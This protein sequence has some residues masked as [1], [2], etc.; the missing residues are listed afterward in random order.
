MEKMSSRE[1]V[2]TTIRHEEPDRVP[3]FAFSVDPKFIKAWG[4]GNPLRAFD[5][6]GL[7][8]F[9]VRV[10]NWCEGVPLV[11][12]LKRE[13]PEAEQTAGGIFAGWNGIDEFGRIWKRGSYIGGALRTR[14]DLARY[15]PPLKL[16]ERTPPNTLKKC[17]ALYPDKAF[18]LN[19]HTGPFGLTMESM[20]FEHFFYSLYDDRD[21]VKEVVDR[22]TEW[23]IGVSRYVQ[24]LGVDFVVMG[25]D[26]AYKGKPFVSPD[27]FRE[28][29]IP[30]YRRIVEALDVPLFWQ[31]EEE[32]ADGAD[33]GIAQ[34]QI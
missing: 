14:E 18:C 6:M 33:D 12:A 9:P 2:L 23:F 8:A 17:Q 1:R 32:G 28:L 20:G 24:D 21:L 4:N 13:I 31:T 25:D 30:Y 11:A 22:R 15:I 3:L 7:D 34:T 5:A 19:A 27:D 16:E 29:G 26:V 10:Q